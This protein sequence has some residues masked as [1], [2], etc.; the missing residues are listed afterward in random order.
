MIKSSIIK[1]LTDEQLSKRIATICEP[2]TVVPLHQYYYH[3]IPLNTV[4]RR[5]N[6]S[7]QSKPVCMVT[8]RQSLSMYRNT[9][10]PSFELYT[11][12][13]WLRSGFR[14]VPEALSLRFEVFKG[15][16]LSIPHQYIEV[17]GRIQ[18]I[19]DF[20]VLPNPIY[21]DSPYGI[22]EIANERRIGGA[23]SMS[24]LLPDAQGY[25]WLE[26]DPLINIP[27]LQ[28][29]FRLS[30]AFCILFGITS[31]TF[32]QNIRRFS[33]PFRISDLQLLR[34]LSKD[35]TTRSSRSSWRTKAEAIVS[36][37]SD[38]AGFCDD[39]HAYTAYIC[40]MIGRLSA[41]LIRYRILHGQLTDHCQNIT[42]GGELT[43]FDYSVKVPTTQIPDTNVADGESR[44]YSQ[45]LLFANHAR[46]FLD[47]IN[48]VGLKCHYIDHIASFITG[49]K[50]CLSGSQTE[51]LL[52]NLD[53]N[54]YCIDITLA[55]HNQF[56]V[57]NLKGCK[58]FISLVHE[59]A[60]EVLR[61]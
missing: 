17:Q 39:L 37:S 59:H 15:L 54:P 27:F 31:D 9:T 24:L 6:I 18:N 40:S 51:T 30:P 58:K 21:P 22:M 36:L 12:Y 5:L 8:P 10:S 52:F 38:L 20:S 50:E 14:I 35:A 3:K 33:N 46:H 43:E 23:I 7:V 45:V 61:S 42:L 32:G 34:L 25:E 55:A 4:S 41:S 44:L 29:L 28:Q 13:N 53:T 2:I 49:I 16:G 11:F 19:Y 48:W 56:S 1:P 57:V 26:G 60:H 47:C